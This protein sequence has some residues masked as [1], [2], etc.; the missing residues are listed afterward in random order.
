[1]AVSQTVLKWLLWC[2]DPIRILAPDITF[3][4]VYCGQSHWECTNCSGLYLKVA[5]DGLDH[6]AFGILPEQCS[7]LD[8]RQVYLYYKGQVCAICTQD[9]ERHAFETVN[10][11]MFSILKTTTWDSMLSLILHL[12]DNYYIPFNILYNQTK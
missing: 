2:F 12:K 3:Y 7:L 1:M 9:L 11:D 10:H 5:L 8:P 4:G 6:A